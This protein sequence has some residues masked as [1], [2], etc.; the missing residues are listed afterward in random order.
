[1][2]VY[3][4]VVHFKRDDVTGLTTSLHPGWKFSALNTSADSRYHVIKSAASQIKDW[5]GGQF[6][7]PIASFFLPSSSPKTV[8]STLSTPPAKRT[9][10]PDTGS[11]ST[12]GPTQDVI[13]VDEV[14]TFAPSGECIPVPT[15]RAHNASELAR[16]FEVQLRCRLT[17][18]ESKEDKLRCPL[19][20]ISEMTSDELLRLQKCSGYALPIIGNIFS[21]YPFQ[22]HGSDPPPLWTPP[23]KDGITF[24]VKCET[25]HL[26][27][28][29]L[30]TGN[31]VNRRCISS[32]IVDL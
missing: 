11:S 6:I 5:S 2:I 8:S 30:R 13:I 7:K 26:G 14:T 1:M 9:K 27:L 12:A 21:N 31:C 28:P 19:Q 3:M 32:S 29:I 25:Y 10:P 17:T 22:I 23:G 4:Q 24:S 16:E 20:I 18:L 15:L